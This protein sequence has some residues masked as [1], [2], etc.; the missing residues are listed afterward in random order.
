MI[1]YKDFLEQIVEGYK[2][3]YDIMAWNEVDEGLVVQAHMH[4]T[5]MQCVI[6]KEFSMWTA[7]ADE[8]VYIFRTSHLTENFVESAILQAY[9]DGMPR[10]DLDGVNIKKQH[11]RTNLVALFICDM[12]DEAAIKKVKKCK[13][14]KNFK[15]SLKGWMEMHTNLVVLN[16]EKVYNNRYGTTTAE[17]LKMHIKHYHKLRA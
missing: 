16:D 13:I 10:I 9:D 7:N 2:N 1:E 17:Y 5:E 11:M 14:Y 12:A 4:V 3:N 6:F 8:Y 15:F